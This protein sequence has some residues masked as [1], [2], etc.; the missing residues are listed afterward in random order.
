MAAGCDTLPAREVE[1]RGVVRRGSEQGATVDALSVSNP[2]P[3]HDGRR[4][5]KRW[6]GEPLRTE[7]RA[8]NAPGRA[9]ST[10]KRTGCVS[11]SRA[12][13][14]GTADAAARPMP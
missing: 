6:E 1:P 12:R 4:G 9:A 8:V 13:E 3:K 10:P 7:S 5:D 14:E 2:P 11:A